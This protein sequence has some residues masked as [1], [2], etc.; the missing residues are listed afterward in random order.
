MMAPS[1]T[2]GQLLEHNKAEKPDELQAEPEQQAGASLAP[3]LPEQQA[4][5]PPLLLRCKD[6]VGVPLPLD[7]EGGVEAYAHMGLCS[8]HFVMRGYI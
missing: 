6:D 2:F 1:N 7:A 8:D 3:P 5:P 4:E